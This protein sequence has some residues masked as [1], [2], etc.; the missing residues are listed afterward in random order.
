MNS[1]TE[2]DRAQLEVLS[3][4]E[5]FFQSSVLFALLKLEIFEHIG[6]RR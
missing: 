5:G 6:R 2:I 3:V 4:A 1:D